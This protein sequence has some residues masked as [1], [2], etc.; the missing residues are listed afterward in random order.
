[1]KVITVPCNFM[2]NG[3][4]WGSSWSVID[5]SKKNAASPVVPP[6]AALQF[7]CLQMT[8]CYRWVY[9]EDSRVAWMWLKGHSGLQSCDFWWVVRWDENSVWFPHYR[10]SWQNLQEKKIKKKRKKKKKEKKRKKEKEKNQF[11]PFV[12]K[13][14]NF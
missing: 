1:M 6:M 11:D 5:T 14:S 4:S 8:I 7:R 2:F 10:L 12:Q 3:C 9:S 13:L